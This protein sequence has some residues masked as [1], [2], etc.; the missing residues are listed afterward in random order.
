LPLAA[1]NLDDGAAVVSFK[2]MLP[3]RDR[4]DA[5]VGTGSHVPEKVHVCPPAFTV[6]PWRYHQQIDIAPDIGSPTHLGAKDDSTLDRD[7]PFM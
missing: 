3:D 5:A 1:G 4:F 6:K 7:T 2:L